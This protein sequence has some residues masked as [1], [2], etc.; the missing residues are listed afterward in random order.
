[1]SS[2]E[3]AMTAELVPLAD[4]AHFRQFAGRFA[5]GVA[6]IA[7]RDAAGEYKGLVVNSV[8]ALSLDPPL[9]LIC[10]DRSSNTLQAIAESGVFSINF[11]SAQQVDVSRRFASKTADKFAGLPV[12]CGPQGAPLIDGTLASCECKV[13][14]THPGGD[15][16]IVIGAVDQVRL[17]EGEPLLFYRG[18]YAVWPPSDKPAGDK[19]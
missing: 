15:H 3:I 16:E 11:L 7:T 2:V 8:T 19:P 13:V 17:G 10:L 18:A 12:T 1:M 9:Y 4:S 6:I 5:T 14:A